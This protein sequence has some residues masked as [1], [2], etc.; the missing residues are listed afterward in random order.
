MED[1][2]DWRITTDPEGGDLLE[3]TVTTRP[4]TKSEH[5][6]I[7]KTS[8]TMDQE[9]CLALGILALES[10]DGK[11]LRDIEQKG[12]LM[13]GWKGEGETAVPEGFE[14]LCS[15]TARECIEQTLK[16]ESGVLDALKEQMI[17]EDRKRKSE[18]LIGRLKKAGE[19]AG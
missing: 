5:V 8:V 3:I 10:V 18:E 6:F 4:W 12:F 7:W 13:P 2:A 14:E 17:Q 19:R 15:R 16:H 11:S 9:G 1:R